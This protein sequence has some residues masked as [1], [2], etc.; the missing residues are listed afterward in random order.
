ML[1]FGVDKDLIY[2]VPVIKL[3][4]NIQY[5]YCTSTVTIIYCVVYMHK[6]HVYSAVFQL[7]SQ[8]PVRKF[9]MF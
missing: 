3:N 1:K 2:Q 5:V 7:F 8:P 6:E 9:S 4:I